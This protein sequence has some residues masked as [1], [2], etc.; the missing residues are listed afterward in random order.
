[1]AAVDSRVAKL[2]FEK[3][4]KGLL[5]GKTVLLVTHHLAFAKQSDH[6]IV[7]EDGSL[8]CEGDF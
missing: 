5:G 3:S 4:I 2:I 8:V 7:M 6:L 1:M